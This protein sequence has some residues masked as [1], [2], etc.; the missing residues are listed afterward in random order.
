[1]Y[2]C[3]NDIIHHH[4]L[5]ILVGRKKMRANRYIIISSKIHAHSYNHNVV[6]R[7]REREREH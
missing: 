1:M 6:L 5:N 4:A 2:C 7:E 3:Y